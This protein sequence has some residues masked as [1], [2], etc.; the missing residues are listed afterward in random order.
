[1]AQ[2][3]HIF[4]SKHALGSLGY[5]Y[6][7]GETTYQLVKSVIENAPVTV[8]S[9]DDTPGKARIDVATKEGEVSVVGLTLALKF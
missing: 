8:A 2:H 4:A 7:Q 3:S 9:G 6:S 1:M 5:Y